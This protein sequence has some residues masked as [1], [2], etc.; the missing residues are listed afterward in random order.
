MMYFIYYICL[1]PI[2]SLYIELSGLEFNSLYKNTKFYKFLHNDLKHYGFIYKKG[3]N[4]DTKLF[5]PNRIC[6]AGG[7]YFCEISKCYLYWTHYGSKV[8]LITIPDDARVYIEDDKFKSNKFIINEII[9][10]DNFPVTGYLRSATDYLRSATGYLRSAAGYLRLDNELWLTITLNDHNAFKYV[11]KTNQTYELCKSVIQQNGL[12][13]KYVDNKFKTDELCILGV[14]K[15]SYALEFVENQNDEICKIAFQKNIMSI[16]FMKDQYKT[17]EMCK[18]AVQKCWSM[19]KYVPKQFQS[20]SSLPDICIIALQQDGHAIRYIINQTDE[21]CKLA[22][23][24][25]GSALYFVKEQFKTEE[26]CKLAVQ[27]CGSALEYVPHSLKT[28][29]VCTLAVKE[30]RMMIHFV[31]SE[32]RF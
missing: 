24:T 13:L 8:A 7:L 28:K 1:H 27:K 26:V 16:K 2:M 20:T 9:D 19:L 15:D 5:N 22:V 30:N 21:L 12:L 23:Q 14:Q 11:N 32:I 18:C 17:Y 3:L 31:P 6:S 25:S 10:F 4:I 29:E